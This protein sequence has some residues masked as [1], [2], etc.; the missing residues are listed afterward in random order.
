MDAPCSFG[1]GTGD[2]AVHRRALRAH[3][4]L[5][6]EA[7]LQGAVLIGI[8]RSSAPALPVDHL[9][10]IAPPYMHDMHGA[11]AMQV[12]Y[13]LY[14]I[15]LASGKDCIQYFAIDGE[16]KKV[17]QGQGAQATPTASPCSALCS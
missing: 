16:E 9:G 6:G 14:K 1:F 13:R 5:P 12:A 10:S 8:R 7:L 4:V 3:A 17:T 11:A 2:A 15:S